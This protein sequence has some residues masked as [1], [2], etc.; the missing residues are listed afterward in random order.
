MNRKACEC[1]RAKT[2]HHRMGSF[3]CLFV[4]FVVEALANI[5]VAD[6]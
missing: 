5:K 4:S 2:A 6:C 1:E 3:N